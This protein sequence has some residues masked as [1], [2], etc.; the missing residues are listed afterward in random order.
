MT[1]RVTDCGGSPSLTHP[2]CCVSTGGGGKRKGRSKKWREILRFPHISQCVELRSSIERDYSSLCVKQPIGRELFRMYCET[3]PKLKN[4]VRLLDAMDQYEVMPDEKRRSHG[5]EISQECV[6]EVAESYG[7]LCRHNLEL[8]PLFLLPPL[9]GTP[10][11]DFQDSMYFDRFLQWKM[12][13]RQPITKETFRQYRVLGKGG[14]GEVCACQV[15]ATGKMYACKKLEKKRIKKR[16]GEAMALNEKQIL[17]QVNS[18][19]VVSLAYAYET[20]DALCLVLTIMNGGDLKFHIYNMGTPGFE[21]ERVQF[22]AA[23]ICCGLEHLH[24]ESIVYRDLKPENILLDDNGHIRISDLG[25]A[26]KVPEGELIRG[27]VGT[28]G[29]M[30]P[31]V[32]SNEKYAMSPDWWGLGCLIYEMTAGR[33]PFRARKERVKREEVEH[34][35][36]EEQEEYGSRFA[37]D[38]EAICRLLLTKD[39]KQ[40]LGC[41]SDGA[42]EVKAQ[43]F[44][45]NIN[46]KRLE[47]GIEEPPF[48]PDPRAVYC[49]DVLDIEQF[50]TVKGVNLDQTDNDFYA[51]FSTGSVSIPWQ[52]EMIETEC[53]KDLNVFGPNGSRPPDLDW[54]Q[55]PEPKI[56]IFVALYFCYYSFIIFTIIVA[57]VCGV[58]F[59]SLHAF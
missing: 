17:E 51:K 28:V 56:F 1:A 45:K 33:S 44:F 18:R 24:R 40:R 32:I 29:Y 53:F 38:A 48:V 23:E 54:D 2:S 55:P 7:Q 49:K 13:E 37:E 3:K 41:Q 30:A 20:K 50:S 12:L 5:E 42:A 6:P 39:P 10:F 59:L 4:C 57:V 36:M 26:I 58:S 47:A 31:E 19:F 34:R 46:F 22:Y 35:V 43:P 52:N 11:M 21:K 8:S 25:L 16:K 15:R 9:H 27:R 14:F